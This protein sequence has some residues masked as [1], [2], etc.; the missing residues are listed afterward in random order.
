[1]KEQI[2]KLLNL[3]P[4]R[5]WPFAIVITGLMLSVSITFASFSFTTR[6]EVI[7]ERP[8][9]AKVLGVEAT[10]IAEP[11]TTPLP[12]ASLSDFKIVSSPK[13]SIKPSASP[14]ASFSPLVSSQPSSNSQNS[15]PVII[16]IVATPTPAPSQNTT[17]SPSPSLEPT[18]APATKKVTIEIKQ[19]DNAFSF[20]IEITEGIN[21]CAVMQ[22]AKDE[23][24]INS[25]T[26]SDK[27]LESFGTLLV[28][29]INGFKNNWV[30]TVNGE[31][32]N[33][34]SLVTLKNGDKVSWEFLN[35]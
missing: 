26:I 31:S 32:P 20:D 13:P 17:P 4:E 19:P 3:K 25:V 30:F 10:P 6:K 1:M 14:L 12:E 16:Q 24:K 28:E 2:S 21:A 11:S 18:P 22:K 15:S 34:C 8:L 9:E 7:V 27:Y 29:E 35:L 5:I 33:G 23:G